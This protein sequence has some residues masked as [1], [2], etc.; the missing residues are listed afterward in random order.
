MPSSSSYWLRWQG[1]SQVQHGKED[2]VSVWS[3]PGRSDCQIKTQV[4]FGMFGTLRSF[5][6]FCNIK[7]ILDLYLATTSTDVNQRNT[8]RLEKSWFVERW[9][10]IRVGISSISFNVVKNWKGNWH[11]YEKDVHF[12]FKYHKNILQKSSNWIEMTSALIRGLP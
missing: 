8:S 3:V 7:P 5:P 10:C 1:F 12:Q 4:Q 2:P 11:P 6:L 9:V